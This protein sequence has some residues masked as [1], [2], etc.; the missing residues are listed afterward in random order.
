MIPV[1]ATPDHSS[2]PSRTHPDPVAGISAA[3]AAGARPRQ[4]N[5]AAA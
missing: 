1:K 5:P 2:T 4:A 3:Q